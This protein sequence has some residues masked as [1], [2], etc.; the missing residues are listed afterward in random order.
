MLP[1]TY[2]DARRWL[3]Q[4]FPNHEISIEDGDWLENG[5]AE[6]VGIISTSDGLQVASYSLVSWQPPRESTS[7][8]LVDEIHIGRVGEF[9]GTSAEQQEFA[10][11]R[12]ASF[13]CTNQ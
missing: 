3:R 8:P 12:A 10:A 9:C 4:A 6:E 13:E 5:D 2:E 7:A 11:T 1:M